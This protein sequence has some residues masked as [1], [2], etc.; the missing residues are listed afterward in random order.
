MIAMRS[1]SR[2]SL[3]TALA[4]GAAAPVLAQGNNPRIVLRETGVGSIQFP[5]GPLGPLPGVLAPDP[6]PSGLASALTF[7]LLGPPSLVAGD[8]FL[9]EGTFLSDVIRFNPSGTGSPTYRASAVFYSAIG[10]PPGDLADTGF[11]SGFYSNT[12]T[13]AEGPTGATYTPAPG[14]PG[15]VA[16]FSVTYQMESL[17]AVPEPSSVVLLATGMVGLAGAAQRKRRRPQGES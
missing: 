13:L 10:G 7:N 8:L 1:V 11:P 16:G 15:Y 2:L 14:Q 3:A 9:M 6:G 5:G 4:I 17:A 12:F